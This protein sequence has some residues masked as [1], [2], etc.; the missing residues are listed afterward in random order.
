MKTLE[1]AG[2]EIIHHFSSGVYAKE[3]RIPSGATLLQHKHKYDHMSILASGLARVIVNERTTLYEA[4]A[5]IDIHAGEAHTV[6]ALSDCV[7]FCVHPTNETDPAK[8]DSEVIIG[9]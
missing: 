5:V 9:E 1:D 2:C 7:W 3:V 8:I 4:P 6:Q